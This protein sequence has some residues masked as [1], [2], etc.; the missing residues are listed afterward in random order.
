MAGTERFVFSFV[1]LYGD[2]PDEIVSVSVKHTV[3]SSS[4]NRPKHDARKTLTITGLESS[5]GGRYLVQVFPTRYRPEGLFLQVKEDEKVEHGF[6]MIPDPDRVTSVTFPSYADLGEDLKRVL[7]H[8]T[9]EGSEDKQGE[10]LY[11]D[12]GDLRTAG[13][14]NLYAKMKATRFEGGRDAFSFVSALKRIRGERFFADVDKDYRDTVK[15]SVLSKLFEKVPGA[16]HNPPVG[17]TLDDSF[18]TFDAA[19]NLQLTFFRK[20]DALEFMV[21]ADIDRSKGLEHVFD[22]VSH[23]ITHKDTHPYDV[24]A[25]LLIDQK[26]DTGYRLV[27]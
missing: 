16:L 3:L 4:A 9:V 22:V 24:H 15:N 27:V 11:K 1:D 6:I 17:Y 7:E 8:S 2:K 20:Q 25:I 5:N 18:K 23:S 21:D 12:L 10:A 19:G 26:I 13:L 14:L